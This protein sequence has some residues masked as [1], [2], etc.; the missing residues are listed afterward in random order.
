MEQKNFSLTDHIHTID[1]FL[2]YR[3]VNKL[4]KYINKIDKDGKFGD[5]HILGDNDDPDDSRLRKEIRNTKNHCLT[6]L[7]DSKTEQHWCNLLLGC[8]RKA[9]NVYQQKYEHI[10]IKDV[11][12]IQ[13]LKYNVGGHYVQHADDHYNISR[14]LSFI[15]R[16]NNDYKGGDLVFKHKENEM[17]RFKTKPNSLVM[18][19]SNFLYPH[20]VEPVTEGVRWSIV[21]WAR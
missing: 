16:I 7:T 5:A 12:D 4:L 14:T 17:I 2:D 21:A 18:W 20:G 13:I 1:E 3:L 9:C 11:N 8:F 10:H 6:N 15:Y 19:P